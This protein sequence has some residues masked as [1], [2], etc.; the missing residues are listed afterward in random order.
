[1]SNP[2]IAFPA[3]FTPANA[4]A[5]ANTDNSAQVVSATAPLPVTMVA[6]VGATAALQTSGNGNLATISAAYGALGATAPVSGELIS[7]IDGTGKLQALG[8]AVFH[9]ADN[10][11][12][13]ATQYGL[14]TGGVTQIINAAGNLDRVRE[15]YGD[16]MAVTGFAGSIG[17]LF[18]GTGYDRPR[19]AAAA[20]ATTGVGIAAEAAFGQY[21]ASAPTLTSGQYSAV[22]LDG[23]GNLKVSDQSYATRTPTQ[24]FGSA[25][26]T[27]STLATLGVSVPTWA[28]M[29]FV[30]PLSGVLYYRTDGTAP[31]TAAGIPIAQGQA[32]PIPTNAALSALQLIAA[33][34]TSFAIEFRG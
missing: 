11:A 34:A 9:N 22:Q 30:I 23:G 24:G 25:T 8:L 12:L 10:Q 1:M 21:N 33:S 20:Q 4:V 26:T 6:G 2:Q 7:G 13:G 16:A 15:G 28:T 32:W 3:S 17:M 14:V 18:N 29:A 27:A 19:A 5:F 31:T